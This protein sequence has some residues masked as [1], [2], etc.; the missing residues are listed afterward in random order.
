MES[1]KNSNIPEIIG[2]NI[3]A[4][5]KRMNLDNQKF[6]ELIYPGKKADIGTKRNK[7]SSLVKGRAI[8]LDDLIAISSNTHTSFSELF[9][10]IDDKNKSDS[11]QSAYDICK[12]IY[13]LFMSGMFN[14]ESTSELQKKG[15]VISIASEREEL[16]EHFSL[17]T[18]I[19][20]INYYDDDPFHAKIDFNYPQPIYLRIMPRYF[21]A[22]VEDPD[23]PIEKKYLF[24][25]LDES[26]IQSFHG[27]NIEKGD[28]LQ[29][30]DRIPLKEF[31]IAAKVFNFLNNIAELKACNLPVS[32]KKKYI[33]IE[34]QKISSNDSNQSPYITVGYAILD[35]NSGEIPLIY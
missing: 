14:I 5:Q 25:E 32:T 33:D 34:F 16:K 1:M 21:L 27:T 4:I 19:N 31:S 26:L 30:G 7:I 22:D 2:H 29:S 12:S 11:T 35:W 8:T 6:Y 13:T 18:D 9:T 28:S 20:T 3:R 10:G 15:K 24:N 23:C 17:I